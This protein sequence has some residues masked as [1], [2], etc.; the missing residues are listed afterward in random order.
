MTKKTTY[1][2]I[3]VNSQGCVFDKVTDT[4]LGRIKSW[5]KDR[6]GVYQLKINRHYLTTTYQIK[7][8]KAYFV[9]NYQG[10]DHGIN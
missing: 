9:E 7:G 10:F 8:N 1:K 5:A 4:N 6:G 2:A 3:L